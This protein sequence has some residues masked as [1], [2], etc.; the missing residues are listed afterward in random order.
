M[1]NDDRHFIRELALR[2]IFKSRNHQ[3]VKD[4]SI[5]PFVIPKVNF[6]AT[7]YTDLI[8]WV[9]L[10]ATPPPILHSIANNTIQRFINNPPVLDFLRFPCH[11]QAVERCVKLV[12]EASR[13]VS[14]QESRD[15]L[16]RARIKSKSCIPSFENKSEYN[17][18]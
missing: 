3:S 17:I 13:S 10:K 6:S 12:T 14:D 18:V 4:T 15:G 11:T 1:L 7:D 5:K 9:D 2:R 16:I 8:D